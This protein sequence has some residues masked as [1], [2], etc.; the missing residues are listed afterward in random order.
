MDRTKEG[1][2]MKQ[3]DIQCNRVMRCKRKGKRKRVEKGKL[4]KRKK[5]K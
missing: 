3:L 5:D 1:K 4:D 2:Y